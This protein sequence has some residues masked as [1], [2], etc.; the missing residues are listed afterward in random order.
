[1]SFLSTPTN[2]T[3]TEPPMYKGLVVVLPLLSILAKTRV[4]KNLTLWAPPYTKTVPVLPNPG[5]M[6]PWKQLSVGYLSNICLRF[7]KVLRQTH[8]KTSALVSDFFSHITPPHFSECSQ[9]DDDTSEQNLYGGRGCP[10][11]FINT[12]R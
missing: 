2:V 1:M 6:L 9:L 3:H 8:L 7:T 10:L 4:F 5:I 11:F 12:N